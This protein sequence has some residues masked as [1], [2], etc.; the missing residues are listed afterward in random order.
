MSIT[1][2]AL[3]YSA[4]W[5]VTHD[6]DYIRQM[7]D[8]DSCHTGFGGEYVKHCVPNGADTVVVYGPDGNIQKFQVT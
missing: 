3:K 4:L 7:Q 5:W 8:G 6:L 1:G 2:D